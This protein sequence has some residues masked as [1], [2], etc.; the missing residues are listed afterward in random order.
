METNTVLLSLDEYNKLKAIE[1]AVA[2][3]KHVKVLNYYDDSQREQ[4]TYLIVKSEAAIEDAFKIIKRKETEAASLHSELYK[5][6]WGKKW[7][8]FWK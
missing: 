1:A 7:Y 6:K 3:G 2:E 8:Q 5:F 4:R